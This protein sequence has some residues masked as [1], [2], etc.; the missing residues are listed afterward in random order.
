MQLSDY[1]IDNRQLPNFLRQITNNIP[2]Q[3]V[4]SLCGWILLICDLI[5]GAN[6]VKKEAV[7]GGQ[8][9][10]F[11]TIKVLITSCI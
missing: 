8:L 11:Y 6:R 1:M 4:I 5:Y 3:L 7:L 10:L 9:P 2:F